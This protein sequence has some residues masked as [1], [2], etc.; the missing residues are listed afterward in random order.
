MKKYF[1]PDISTILVF[2][3]LTTLIGIGF[4]AEVFEA[5]T[6]EVNFAQIYSNPLPLNHLT[7]MRKINLTNK[8][9]TFTFEN[10]NPDA[11]IEGPW[12]M[13]SPQPLKA[14]S[15]I[16]KKII[17][18]LKGIR[19]R[20]FHR[21]EPLNLTSF[22]LDN[23]TLILEIEGPKKKFEIKMGLINP[24]DNSAFITVSDQDQIY[25]IDPLE[26]SL[27]SYDLPQLAES[28]VLAM[29]FDSLASM[30]LY[31]ANNLTVKVLKKD[32]TW[33]DQNGVILS[34]NK[35]KDFMEKIESIKSSS[36]LENLN[37]EQ[38]NFLNNLLSKSLYSLKIISNIGVRSY[39]F[40]ELK[41]DP[42]NPN[43][44]DEVFGSFVMASEERDSFILINNQELDFF[45]RGIS[46]LK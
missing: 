16:F 4:I 7:K 28:K 6:P 22:S 23:P 20:N 14:K 44:P 9:G 5:E 3:F 25:Q 21:L 36:I 42:L 2:F 43:L 1:K 26:M 10:I 27:E 18:S 46:N 37:V 8:N 40:S 24:I 11:K 35:V 12:Q 38:K 30:E 34:E 39:F 41:K 33:L 32:N 29:N 19:V 17:Q 45:S 15:E 13:T 31:E